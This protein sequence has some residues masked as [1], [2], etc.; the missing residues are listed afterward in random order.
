MGAASRCLDPVRAHKFALHCLDPVRAHKFAS[1]CLARVCSQIRVTLPRACAFKF[2][3]HCLA[4]ACA[5]IRVTLP[6]ACARTRILYMKYEAGI[7]RSLFFLC[8]SH[9]S[10][11]NPFF[12]RPSHFPRA[13]LFFF[14][15]RLIFS[16]PASFS[17]RPPLFFLRPPHFLPCPSHFPRASLFLFCARL[18]FAAARAPRVAVRRFA[19]HGV[20]I[21]AEFAP[22]RSAANS[23]YTS[24]C[25]C[26]H[27]A[28]EFTKSST[29]KYTF[30]SLRY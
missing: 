23:F 21:P 8:P 3:S 27:S 9:F 11:R 28:A 26:A 5:Q 13:S 22:P 20:Q 6:R 1:R 14:R 29:R 15:A 16:A 30:F 12:P 10:P 19:A 18:F 7:P 24:L 2:A 17:P 25:T 4:R